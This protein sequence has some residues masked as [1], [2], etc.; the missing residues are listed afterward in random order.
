MNVLETNDRAAGLYKRLGFEIE[1]ILKN[2]K[3]LSDGKYHSTVV[4]GRL[5]E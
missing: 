3:I 4:M 2:D 5:N 1:G